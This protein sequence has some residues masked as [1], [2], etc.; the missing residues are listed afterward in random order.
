M[1]V[2]IGPHQ[3]TQLWIQLFFDGR[4]IKLALWLLQPL[5]IMVNFLATLACTWR[6]ILLRDLFG[7]DSAFG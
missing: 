2:T 5:V 1:S 6:D 3:S 4:T 7:F